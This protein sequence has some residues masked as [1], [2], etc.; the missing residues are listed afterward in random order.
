LGLS[1]IV[2]DRRLAST[3]YGVDPAFARPDRPAYA[4]S[5]GLIAW[6][7]SLGVS[8]ALGPDWRAFGFA[9][10]DS[11]SGAANRESPLVKATNG[12]SVGVGLAYTWRRSSTMAAD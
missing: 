6:R 12:A 10:W 1:A 7:A 8:A 4:A 2:G 9:R 5:S 3:F 11:V